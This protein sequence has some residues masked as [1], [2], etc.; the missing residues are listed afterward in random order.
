MIEIVLKSILLGIALAMDACAIS[1]ANGLKENNMKIKKILFISF[2]FALFQGVMPLIGYSVGSVILSKI[3]YLI[4]WVSLVILS[5]LGVKMIVEGV[6]FKKESSK[7]D[8]ER[9]TLGIILLQAVATS[10][11]ALSVGFTISNYTILQA[12]L[13]VSLI[14]VV[15]FFICFAGVKIGEKCGIELGDKAQILGGIILLIIGFEIF[16]NGL[17]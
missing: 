7:D 4:P 9:L 14:S 16:I 6:K 5:I 15:T 17:L 2:M 12:L 11:D 8:I 10:I 3:T 1:M 13:C